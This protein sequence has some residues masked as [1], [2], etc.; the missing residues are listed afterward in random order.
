MS[1]NQHLLPVIKITEKMVSLRLD[2]SYP[3]NYKRPFVIMLQ[4]DKRRL[5]LSFREKPKD[6][7]FYVLLRLN[8]CPL[9]LSSTHCYA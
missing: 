9:M 3:L 6:L 5:Q 7:Q 1:L 2:I 4:N 8:R